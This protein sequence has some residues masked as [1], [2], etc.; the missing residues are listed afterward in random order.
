MT[1]FNTEYGN[2]EATWFV[3]NNVESAIDQRYCSDWKTVDDCF[4]AYRTNLEDDLNTHCKGITN[5]ENF[6][7]FTMFDAKWLA[8]TQCPIEYVH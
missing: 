6:E 5:E 2:V 7:M 8:G 1:T 3:D 4:W